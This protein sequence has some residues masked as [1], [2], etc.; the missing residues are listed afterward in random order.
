[1]SQRGPPERGR[2]SAAPDSTCACMHTGRRVSAARGRPRAARSRPSGSQQTTPSM[3]LQVAR[4]SGS[5]HRS[6]DGTASFHGLPRRCSYCRACSCLRSTRKCRRRAALSCRRKKQLE[7]LDAQGTDQAPA[8][9]KAH[10]SVTHANQD[11]RARSSAGHEHGRGHRAE[12]GGPQPP[13]SSPA[14]HIWRE[15]ARESLQGRERDCSL[16]TWLT[17]QPLSNQEPPAELRRGGS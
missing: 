7:A 8:T 11:A 12:E 3:T 5:A 4:R 16:L 9:A 2:P 6:P 15:T 17:S 1:M 14:C 10:R 13:P